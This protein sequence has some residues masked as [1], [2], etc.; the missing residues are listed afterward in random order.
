MAEKRF[1]R[2]LRGPQQPV[3]LLPASSAPATVVPALAARR[4][5]RAMETDKE[6]AS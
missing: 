5:A 6:N 2:L 4:G 1:Q 3:D